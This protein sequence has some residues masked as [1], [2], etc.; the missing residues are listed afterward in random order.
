MNAKPDDVES[1]YD[2]V[3]AEYATRI[4]GELEHKPLDR[5]LL[6]RLILRV[7]NLG[8]ICDMGCGPGHVAGYLHR[9]GATVCGIDLSAGMLAE[10]RRLHPD[11]EFRRSSMLALNVADAAW[12]GIAAFYSLIHIPRPD[13]NAALLELQRTLKPGG[14]LLA[15]FHIGD[16]DVHR[17]E[18]WGEPVTLDFLFFQPDEMKNWITAAGFDIH[19]VIERDPYENVEHP[20][21]RAYIFAQKPLSSTTS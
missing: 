2:R 4:A 12:G 3:A 5:E 18:L 7:Q 6:D 14:W 10:A 16:E 20:S 15:A 8:P 17:D 19:E 9:Q 11:I 1:S 13:M 21:R